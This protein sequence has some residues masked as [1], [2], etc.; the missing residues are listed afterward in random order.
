MNPLI[1]ETDKSSFNNN[2]KAEGSVIFGLNDMTKVG[3]PGDLVLT[4]DGIDTNTENEGISEGVNS[5]TL[6]FL[7]PN[8][9]DP[10]ALRRR[11]IDLYH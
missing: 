6:A 5:W 3:Q 1:S 7:N 9:R 10:F 2:Q 11:E 8:P 4:S